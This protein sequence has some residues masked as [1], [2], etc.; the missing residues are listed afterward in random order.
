MTNPWILLLSAAVGLLSGLFSGLL[1]RRL[2]EWWYQP[3][4]VLATQT[5]AVSGRR[6]SGKKATRRLL[7]FT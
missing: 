4:L 1:G 5:N 7:R 3:K 6:G 2:E